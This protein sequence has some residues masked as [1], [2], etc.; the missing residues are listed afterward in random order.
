MPNNNF[1][2]HLSSLSQLSERRFCVFE[3]YGVTATNFEFPKIDQLEI[4]N[5]LRIIKN[6]I[7]TVKRNE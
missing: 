1:K 6:K 2:N 5:T 7:D 4:P 3:Q